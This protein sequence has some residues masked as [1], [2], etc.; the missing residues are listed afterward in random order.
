MDSF[1]KIVDEREK[2]LL[3]VFNTVERA[4]EAYRKLRE[5]RLEALLL[6]SRIIS[7]ERR[8]REGLFERENG[9]VDVVIATQVVEAG[10]DFDFKT[11]VTEVSP[12]DSLIQ[13]LGRG[14]RRR[15]GEA[16]IFTDLGQAKAVYP[17][18]VMKATLEA[19]DADKLSNSM[20]DVLKA[21]GLVNSVY[22][23]DVVEQLK[24]EISSNLKK[25]LAFIKPFT[26]KMFDRREFYEDEA[27]SLLRYSVEVR[28]ILLP[29]NLYEQALNCAGDGEILLKP[30]EAVELFT[31]NSL[32]ISL[33]RRDVEIPALQHQIGNRKVYLSLS[34][35]SKGLMVRKYGRIKDYVRVGQT[36]HLTIN[37]NYYEKMGEYHLGLVK[38]YG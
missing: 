11:V 17:E 5:E 20:R 7:G 23:H 24:Q 32:S 34:I 26:N 14:A 36:G 29:Q 19:L 25:I 2:P 1:P 18:S 12:I 4:V 30:R 28:C 38:P 6:H 21:S 9:K 15:D 8:R 3:L 10:I 13:R 16:V 37:P 33:P 31:A 27:S 22:T 35:S